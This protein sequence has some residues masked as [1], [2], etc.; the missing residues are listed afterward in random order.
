[1]K[2]TRRK[3]LLHKHY[4]KKYS[5]TT[6]NYKPRYK[7]MTITTTPLTVSQLNR[8]VAYLLDGSLET[9]WIVGE[10]ANLA[11][12]SSGHYYFTLKDNQAQIRCAMFRH[13]ASR[14]NFKLENGQEVKV[15][16]KVSLYQARGDYQ[17][18]AEQV[19][20]SGE[21]VLQQ[22]FLKLQK[23]LHA[24][25]LFD[26]QHKQSL[27]PH[28]NNIGLI[29]SATGAALRDI[30]VV[31]RRRCPQCRIIIYP[32]LVQGYQ[33]A[34]TIVGAI[35]KA[36]QRSE[37]DVVVVARG[38]GSLEDLW[39]FN[40]EMVVRAIFSSAIPIITGIGHETDTTLSDLVADKRAATPSAAAELVSLHTRE[41]MQK[42]QRL[43][44]QAGSLLQLKIYQQQQHIHK[45]QH[46]IQQ[47][48]PQLIL[49]NMQQQLNNNWQL[50]KQKMELKIKNNQ[51]KLKHFTAQLEMLNPLKV[52]AR[53][54]SIISTAE[55]KVITSC[56][57]LKQ[58]NIITAKL[59]DGNVTATVTNL[60]SVTDKR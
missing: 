29:T 48:N 11:I 60:T 3:P 31:L 44:L 19:I 46:Q 49:N 27:P 34:P 9:M 10:V 20:A 15:L 25:G 33:A 5:I 54:Y 22:A 53:G 32:S 56:R 37:C 57:Q 55:K 21:G 17:L 8:K 40:E 18:I 38:G 12:P 43:I 24:E 51:Q 39:P 1:M 13:Q 42:M 7:P 36:N 26:P 28:P 16:A 52:I 4:A 47:Q 2:T 35:N 14:L 45:L 50:I 59:K 41:L 30:L 23:K 58:G 6:A